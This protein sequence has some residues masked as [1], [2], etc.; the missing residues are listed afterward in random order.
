MA[1][2]GLFLNVPA[3]FNVFSNFDTMCLLDN[4]ADT[5]ICGGLMMASA[6]VFLQS[7]LFVL[8]RFYVGNAVLTLRL[9]L[10]SELAMWDP[11]L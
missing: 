2:N 11:S 10:W 7:I 5:A 9:M 6:V 1:L 3:I 4:L 8:P